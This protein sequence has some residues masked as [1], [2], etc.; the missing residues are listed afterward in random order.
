VSADWEAPVRARLR[1]KRVEAYEDLADAHLALG[2]PRDASASA[3]LALE[4]DRTRES[5]Y[6]RLM[7]AHYA[8]GEQD[9][10]LAAY[11]RCRR[12]LA[13]ELGVDPLPETMTLHERILRRVPIA[14]SSA[15]ATERVRG[16]PFVAREAERIALE[17][18]IARA[19]Q[20]RLLV[21]VVG[22]AGAGKTR[23]VREAVTR[24]SD[25]AVLA[26]RCYER[27]GELP[28]QP[29]RDAL[30]DRAPQARIDVA[31]DEGRRAL[32]EAYA[33]A[34]LAA[35][36]GRPLVWTIDDVQWADGSTLDV[37]HFVLRRSADARIAVVAAGRHDELPPEHY[38]TRLLTDLRREGR[39]ERIALVPLAADDVVALA[40]ATGLSSDRAVAIHARSG[41]NAFFVTELLMALR[42]G[43]TSLPETA[44]DA[45][46]ARTHVLPADAREVLNAAAVLGGRFQASEVAGVSGLE[47]DSAVRALGLLETHDLVR[48][49]TPAEHEIVHDLVRES[50]YEDIPAAVRGELHRRAIDAVAAA[51]GE[52]AASLICYHAEIAS[53][54]DCAFACATMAGERALADFAG[55][56]AIASFDRALRQPSDVASRQRCLTLRAEA[57][58]RLGLLDDAKADVAAAA[59]LG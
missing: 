14:V 22:E 5:A 16:L 10:A 8:A 47:L 19:A 9:A 56:E 24:R 44:R 41:G 27:E 52:P 3:E 15:R 25:I 57:K 36:E 33:N 30:G 23:L 7:T 4:I 26:T 48:P 40:R 35:A 21:L 39:G 55:N 54:A 45:V 18:A 49:I 43:S 2:R 46:L 53:D 38:V 50:V 11:E 59:A 20:E 32:I 58:R 28:F 17:A 34:V 31:P 51:R 42:R 12:V 37:L 1:G 29:I 6:R 13:D